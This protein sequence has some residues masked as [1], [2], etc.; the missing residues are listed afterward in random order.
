MA[1]ITYQ[2]FKFELLKKTNCLFSNEVMEEMKEFGQNSAFDDKSVENDL[3]FR[4]HGKKGKKF[5]AFQAFRKA[6]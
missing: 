5:S 6:R 2:Q 4:W 3:Q 1:K